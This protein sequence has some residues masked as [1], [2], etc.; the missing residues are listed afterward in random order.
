LEGRRA[1]LRKDLWTI[2]G[3]CDDHTRGV[4]EGDVRRY[5]SSI[6][7]LLKQY[8]RREELTAA[9]AKARLRFK[10][11]I[12]TPADKDQR[13]LLLKAVERSATLRRVDALIYLHRLKVWLAPHVISTSVM[14]ALMV[15]HIVQVVF[16]KVR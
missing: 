15:V 2:T 16:F 8:L 6:G 9:L 1:E 10:T 12:M 13:N 5:F 7:Y 3:K 4:I 11:E 14:L